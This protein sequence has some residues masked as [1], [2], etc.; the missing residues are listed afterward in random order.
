MVRG[1]NDRFAPVGSIGAILMSNSKSGKE[2]E[3][4]GYQGKPNVR[5]KPKEGTNGFKELKLIFIISIIV[6]S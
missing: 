6:S 2:A 4:T 5:K 3:A 1:L